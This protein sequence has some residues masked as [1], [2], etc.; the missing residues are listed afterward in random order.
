M[1]AMH[2]SVYLDFKVHDDLKAMPPMVIESIK[3]NKVC[4]IE[5]ST[6]SFSASQNGSGLVL[7]VAIWNWWWQWL[8]FGGE[9][10]GFCAKRVW[11]VF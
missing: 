3:K 2:A 10:Y 4:L 5:S 6:R 8:V 11:L 7:M 1:E 9:D